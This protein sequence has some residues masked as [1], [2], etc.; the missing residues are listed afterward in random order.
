MGPQ[1]VFQPTCQGLACRIG[2]CL[3]SA[4]MASPK[5]MAMG[6]HLESRYPADMEQPFHPVCRFSPMPW[7]PQ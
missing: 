2:E 1:R 3:P 7:L 6:T 5:P 4:A